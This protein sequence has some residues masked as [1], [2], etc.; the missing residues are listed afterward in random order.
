MIALMRLLR[1]VINPPEI[2]YHE[3]F[4]AQRKTPEGFRI[5]ILRL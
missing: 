4:T 1:R 3:I 5:Q 2:L